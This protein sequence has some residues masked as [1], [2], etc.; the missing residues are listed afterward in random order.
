MSNFLSDLRFA[1]RQLRRDPGFALVA[2]LTLGVGIGATT[3]VF[4]VFNG[5]VLRELPYPESEQLVRL[6][7]VSP[8]G[9]LFSLSEPAFLDLRERSRSFSHLAAVS[10][11]PMA[12]VGDSDT[13]LVNGTATT[14]GLFEMLGAVPLV[15]RAFLPG[16]FGAGTEVPTV[17]IGFGVWESRFG[18]DPSAIGRTLNLD[19]EMRTIVGVMPRGF[20]FPYHTDV[21]LPFNPNHNAKR[22]EHVLE[23][24]GRLAPGV[25]LALATADIDVIASQLGSEFP[26]SNREWGTA[27]ITFREWQIG[28]SA[29][30]IAIV[31]LGTVGLLL[32]LACASVSNLL[33]A[34]TT[35]R[36]RELALRASLGALRP[37]ILGQLIAESLVLAF[38]SAC[39]GLFFAAWVLPV[40]QMLETETL[41]RLGEVTIDRTVLLFTV[42]I[43]VITGV[44][45]GA[46]PAFQASN[47]SFEQALRG[48]ER[49]V[50]GGS[51]RVREVLVTGQLALAVVLLVGAGLLANS[52]VRLLDN[53]PN[54]GADLGL[55]AALIGLFATAALGLAALGIYG[56]TAFSVARRKR[57]IGV[58]M[59]LGAEPRRIIGIALSSGTKLI[60]LGTGIGL[61]GAFGL[62]RFL[63]SLLYEIR[64][65]DPFTYA[66]VTLVLAIVAMVANYLPA[67][68][69][70]KID[71]RVA[72][73]SE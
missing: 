58:R 27:L 4:S 13:T 71:P 19:G 30:R 54:A 36:Q 10:Y 55:S 22:A 69:A 26:Q 39:V 33:L 29:T 38:F 37:R 15:G 25:S 66:A 20:A 5:T 32:L 23:S 34:R 17:V 48:G 47:E 11:R 62:S 70:T 43:T 40:I 14:D 1:V 3:V 46:A 42:F 41:P 44:L 53:D 21:W 67:R 61:I 24:F 2:I 51:R 6:R 7:E 68:R 50:T 45:C 31:L 8:E 63:G 16:D 64:P 28:P 65:S 56:V 35:G 49:I 72:F 52:F 60:A 59:A 18:G 9:H 73:E 12:V 57:E